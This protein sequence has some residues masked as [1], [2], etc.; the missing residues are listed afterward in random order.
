MRRDKKHKK[1]GHY[2]EAPDLSDKEKSKRKNGRPVEK[3]ER[4]QEKKT[5]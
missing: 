4:T 5:R 1:E 3:T 2:N